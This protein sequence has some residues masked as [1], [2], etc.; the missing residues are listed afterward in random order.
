MNAVARLRLK[1]AV[2]LP[3]VPPPSSLPAPHDPN[4]QFSLNR[5]LPEF[6]AWTKP[7]TVSLSSGPSQTETLLTGLVTA[8]FAAWQQSNLPFVVLRNYEGLPHYTSHDVD[9]LLPKRDLA[10]AERLLREAAYRAGFHLSNRAE[11]SPISLF[12]FHPETGLQTQFDLFHTL[13]WRSIPL[14]DAQSV[15]NWR[16]ER[17]LFAI[18][19]PVHEAVNNLLTRQLHHG[20]VKENYKESIQRTLSEFPQEGE[21]VLRRLFGR[22]LGTQLAD[23]IQASDW[24]AVE[25]LSSEMRRH[26]IRHRLR[27]RPWLIYTSFFR[28]LRRYLMR[29]ARPPGAK[30]VL[31]GADGSG[32]SSVAE[33]L[34]DALHATFYK[35]KSIH[36]HWKPAMFLR[37]RRAE[38]PPTTNPHSQPP[39]GWLGSQLALAYHWVE[40]FAGSVFKYLPVL[41]RNGL[42]LIE[43]HHY[44]FIADPR[45]Y[46][47]RLPGATERYAFRLLRTP[48]LVF[49]LD[50]PP[51]VLHARKPELSLEET[52]Q[53]REAYLQL[54]N[55]LPNGRVIDATQPLDAVVRRIVTES[56]FY[57]EA[58]LSRREG[59]PTKP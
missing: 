25:A 28:D 3:P 49:L 9:V 52:R 20:Y 31:L 35:D 44:D 18:P 13:E 50:A 23:R 15:L 26:L 32:K 12:L 36:V 27:A 59:R 48:D 54:V 1:E 55:S 14:L 33:R 43:R 29:V 10:L 51:E 6:P 21:T 45:R 2:V 22:T 34:L 42:V 16:V 58:R 47:L 5:R 57:L 19:H 46:R 30:I 17:G 53:R 7:M 39:R 38:R 37:Q 24:P 40:F 11:F 56:L 41:F 4:N 8:V